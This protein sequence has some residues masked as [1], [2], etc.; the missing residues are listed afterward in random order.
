MKSF[1]QFFTESQAVQQATRMGLQSDGHGGWTD[2]TGKYV[3]KTEGGKL[4][5]F[6]GRGKKGEE[7]PEAKRKPAPEP[8]SSTFPFKF[9]QKTYN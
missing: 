9:L 6:K 7:E 4:V 2:R 5:F 3:A 1:F 8:K